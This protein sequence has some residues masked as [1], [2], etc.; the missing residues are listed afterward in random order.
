[1]RR[2]KIVCTLGPATDSYDQ[3]KALVEAGMDVARFNLSHGSYADHEARYHRVRKASEELGRSVGVLADLQGPKIR[4]GRFREGPVLLERGDTFVI[5]V[6]EREGDRD[7]CGTT[8]AGLA[9]DVTAGERILVDDGRVTLEVTA[10]DGPRVRTTVI[11]GGMVSDHKGLN[12][13]G[14]AVS[15]PALSEKDIQ[16][17]RW[18]LETGADVIALS[19]VRSG[20]DIEDVHRVMDEA[21]R[22]VPVIAKIEKPQAVTHIEDI[23]AAFDGIMV[24]RGDLGV[25][26]PLEQVPIVQK[27]AIKLAKRNAKPVIV[28][29]QMLDSMIDNSRPTRAEASD[30]ANAVIDGTDAVMLSGETSVGKYPVETVRT[31]GRIVTAAEEDVLAQGLPPLTVRNKPRTQGGAVARAA[32]EIGDFLGAAFLVAFTQSGDTVRRLSRYRSPIPLLA[33]TPDPA[34]RSQLN[35]TWGVESF[36]GPRVE[37]TDAMV[38]QV[39]EELLRIG[40]CR[41]GDLVVITAGSPPGVPGST[42]LVRVHRIG[43]SDSLR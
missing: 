41:R 40:R 15:V 38:A 20:K 14:V 35:L 8:Y 34:T 5:T 10:V 25:E 27:R 23:V 33:F 16:D 22:R 4:L 36:L 13:P 28:A 1:M 29:T 24:A 12:L 42:N 18:A 2:A 37:S 7:S 26:M 6:E 43:E 32:A 21:G 3:I 19:F 39:D 30:V 31:M 11:E 17:L 9:A